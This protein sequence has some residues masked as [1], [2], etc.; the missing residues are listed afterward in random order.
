MTDCLRKGTF[1]WTDAVSKSFQ[2]IKDKMTKAPVLRL[3]DFSKSFEVACDASGL[4]IGGVL[5]QEGHPIAYFS[6]KLKDA[7]LRY[8]NY[9][10]KFYAVVQTLR[11]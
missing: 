7:Q 5:N 2:E 4:G 10:R 8:S 6:E 3:P 1:A 9:N 11:H